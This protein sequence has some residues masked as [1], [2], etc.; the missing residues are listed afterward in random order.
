MIDHYEWPK[1]FKYDDN[2]ND[3]VSDEPLVVDEKLDTYNA[4]EKLE[5]L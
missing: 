2:I 5:I 1:G 3:D 4:L